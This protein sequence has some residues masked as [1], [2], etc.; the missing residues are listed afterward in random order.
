M[1]FADAGE[2]NE[3]VAGCIADGFGN[4]KGDEIDERTFFAAALVAKLDGEGLPFGVNDGRRA[5]ELGDGFGGQRGA[6]D[7]D[8]QV[9]TNGLPQAD[10][11]AKDKVHFD[12][13]L[14]EFIDDDGA[15]IVEGDI[16]EQPTEK[17]AGR[18]D[19][20]PRIARGSLVE[21]HLVTDF[22]PELATAQVSDSPSDSAGSESA[23]LDEDESLV[24]R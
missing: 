3:D 7:D 6:H 19:D 16:V 23:R 5:E 14:V 13:A 18:D 22:R 1:D 9:G 24:R 10:E 21:S 12:R 11:H 20:E 4:A 2:E 15:R 17:D 8:S